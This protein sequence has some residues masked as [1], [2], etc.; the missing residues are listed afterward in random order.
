MSQ[1]NYYGGGGGYSLTP[2]VKNLL[3][4]NVLVYLLTK[5]FPIVA[6]WGSLKYGFE[7]LHPWQ[8]I[9]YMFLHAN[10]SHLLF[11]M[12]ALW[13][14]GTVLEQTIGSKRFL[15]FYLV[16]GIG[17]ALIQIIVLNLMYPSTG[18]FIQTVGA[19]GAVFGLLFAFGYLYPNM[20]IYFYFLI[21]IAAKYFVILYAALELYLGL[22]N[23]VGD[24]VA[25]FAHLGGMLFAFILLRQWKV[26]R[27]LY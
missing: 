26:P 2:V 21:P 10:F 12:L 27:R 19:S 9:T 17:A 16:C 20:K 22:K 13:M 15:Y 8:F 6:A 18:V 3:I 1:Y 5:A 25:H 14:F 23:S 4:I 11:N 7:H 24:N